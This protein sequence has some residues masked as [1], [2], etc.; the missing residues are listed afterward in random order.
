MQL[1]RYIAGW[2]FA[3]FAPAAFVVVSA[4]MLMFVP[5]DPP[6]V[7]AHSL[8]DF[9]LVTWTIP[10]VTWTILAVTWTIPAATWT[11]PAVTWTIPAVINWCFDCNITW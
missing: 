11:I 5:V 9:G 1:Q 7:G 2:R 4:A 10:A 3:I 8:P 6:W